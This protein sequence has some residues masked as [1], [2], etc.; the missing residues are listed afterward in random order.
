MRECKFDH[1][2]KI[3]SLN[4]LFETLLHSAYYCTSIIVMYMYMYIIQY[5]M[6]AKG[7]WLLL[8]SFLN[9]NIAQ[10]YKKLML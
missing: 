8:S 9:A 3:H 4:I 1:V 5:R 7:V 2:W 6:K 10:A